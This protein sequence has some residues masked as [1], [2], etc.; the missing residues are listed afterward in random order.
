MSPAEAKMGTVLRS[1]PFK[2]WHVRRQ[3]QIG[4]LCGFVCVKA[5]LMIEIDDGQH[6]EDGAVA[7]DTRRTAVIETEG[8][9]VVRFATTDVMQHAAGVAGVLL[10]DLR[11]K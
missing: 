11:K 9:R 8:Y 4:P 5:R 2:A 7:Y 10:G 6:Y 3:V 1:E